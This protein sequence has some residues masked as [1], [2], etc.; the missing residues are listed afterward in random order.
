[1][2]IFKISVMKTTVALLLAFFFINSL[3]AQERK[4]LFIGIDGVRT[5]AL[6][7]ANTPNLDA[8][9]QNGTYS[10]TS[11]HVGVTSSGPSWSDMLTGVWENKHGVTNNSYTNSNYNQYP[12]FVTRAK[13]HRPNLKAVQVTTWGPMSNNVYNDGWDSKLLVPN[14][15]DVVNAAQ[16]QLLDPD[17]DV[18]FVHI[19]DV[20]A[21]GH[22]NGFSPL[23]S[24]YKNQIET[25]DG[26]VGTILSYLYARPGYQNGSEEWLILLTTD[27]GGIGFGHGG[28]TTQEKEIWWAGVGCTMDT[29][30]I[31]INMNDP[32]QWLNAP[33]LVDIAVTALD[34]LL[35][36]IQP[37]N[38]AA[39]DLDGQS[40]CN[41][42]ANT[43][44]SSTFNVQEK[45]N[46]FEV[47][48][49]PSTGA[50]K[51]VVKNSS[52]TIHYRMMDMMGKEVL[53]RSIRGNVGSETILDID[54]SNYAKGVY[55]LELSNGKESV[56]QKVILK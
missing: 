43:V 18:L 23:I 25:V 9:F 54:A 19:D 2:P 30:Q 10:Y 3:S 47:F 33:M 34:H 36:G 21:A 53:K 38:V 49:N 56:T 31:S 15:A 48:P 16:V 28:N 8:L 32:N 20:D 52:E 1:M 6:Q 5:D 55:T 40:W 46:A 42:K 29:T 45:I 11:W 13:E 26:Q 17:L 51:A 44:V 27:H 50:F 41:S 39:W 14:D 37:E 24:P 12:Y 22:G 4:V 35:V 7:Q